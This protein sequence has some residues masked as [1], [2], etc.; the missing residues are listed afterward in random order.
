M[1]TL[2]I[3][4]SPG[5]INKIQKYL[6][7][8]YIVKA[9]CGHIRDLPHDDIHIDINN[10]FKPTYVINKDKYKI[11]K[12]LVS[13]RASCKEVIIAT[14]NDREGE[15][16]AQSLKEILKLDNPKRIVFNEITKEALQYSINNPSV[17]DINKV[18]SQQ[19][20]R[21]LDRIIGYKL[22]PLLWKNVSSD[23]K[24]AGR[25]QSIALNIIVNKEEEIQNFSTENNFSLKVNFKLRTDNKAIKSQLNYEFNNYDKLKQFITYINI[26]TIFKIEKLVNKLIK[27]NPE[28]PFI[29]STLQ[30]TAYTRLGMSGYKTMLIAQKLYEKGFITYMRTDSYNLSNQTIQQIK[31]YIVDTY[32]SEYYESKT[33]KSKQF[34]QD[35]HECIRPTN[36]SLKKL[37]NVTP[38][39]EKLYKLIWYRTIES[40]MSS[41]IINS[42]ILSINA[43]NKNKTILKIDDEQ[44]YFIS[45]N[46]TITFLGYKILYNDVIEDIYK[47]DFTTEIMFTSLNGEEDYS[48]PPKRFNEG[49]L[50][51][52][53]DK[54]NIGRPS[55]Y[56]SIIN[57]LKDR[58]YIKIDNIIGLEKEQ[59][60]I[61]MDNNYIPEEKIN[62]III[63][64]EKNVF[65]PSDIGISVNT[66]LHDKF[67]DII[68]IKFTSEMEENLDKIANNTIDYLDILKEYYNILIENIN[69]VT[70]NGKDNNTYVKKNN[71]NKDKV[72]GNKNN[73]TIYIG[74]GKF[75]EYIKSFHDDKWVYV[76]IE[77]LQK[78]KLNIDF[79]YKL[80]IIKINKNI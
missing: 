7:N 46:N 4:E 74:K 21:F 62:K 27:E 37:I 70:E 79:A 47:F 26:N 15:F 65:I 60:C 45:T 43:L 9:S 29:T 23:A 2:I 55:T 42:D 71:Y 33:F 52:Y 80:L 41:C 19:T 66:F 68:N 13:M 40:Q 14:D 12:E 73:M 48:S 22:S 53:L 63:G 16:I 35:A 34:T 17:I 49:S 61:I 3:V 77:K 57:K 11:V 44:Y 31:K 72:F 76:S 18:N 69:K 5:K 38:E 58:D 25:V 78:S 59:R 10:D 64:S 8:E 20:R 54:Y 36:I 28:L 50:I 67:K 51:K 30:Q 56:V 39:E 1:K 24:S 32:G 75:G 6:G